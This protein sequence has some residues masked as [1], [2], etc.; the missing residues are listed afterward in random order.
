M[1]YKIRIKTGKELY[2]GTD[3]IVEIKIIGSA[4]ETKF[5]K[6]VKPFRNNFE[7]GARDSFK[8]TSDDVGEIECISLKV[9]NSLVVIEH[10]REEF[11]VVEVR[12]DG[13]DVAVDV[14]F[15]R[16]LQL[17]VDLTNHLRNGVRFADDVDDSLSIATSC[18]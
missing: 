17:P 10:E 15:R 8:I 11:L 5:H 9:Q 13:S 7:R 3:S 4:A 1:D 18:Q 12:R 14:G 16:S 2:S 6:L